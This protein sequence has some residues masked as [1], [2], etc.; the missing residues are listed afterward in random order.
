MA[1]KVVSAQGGAIIFRSTEGKGSVFGFSFPLS[2]TEVKD[3]KTPLTPKAEHN[4]AP[5]KTKV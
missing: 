4:L 2:A 1:K 3:G 5:A